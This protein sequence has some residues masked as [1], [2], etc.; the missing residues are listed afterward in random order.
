MSPLLFA[1]MDAYASGRLD[2]YRYCRDTA[3]KYHPGSGRDRWYHDAI[4]QQRQYIGWWRSL[5][6][7]TSR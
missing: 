3:K 2:A 4:R 5:W 7:I 6:P 1:L